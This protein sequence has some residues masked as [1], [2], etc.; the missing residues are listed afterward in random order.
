MGLTLFW[1][2]I[3]MSSHW[4]ARLHWWRPL[5]NVSKRLVSTIL[6]LVLAQKNIDSL[7]CRPVHAPTYKTTL[8]G[9]I[10]SLLSRQHHRRF[11]CVGQVIFKSH[12]NALAWTNCGDFCLINGALVYLGSLIGS[13]MW[14]E[15]NL[16]TTGGY[17][18]S[19][20][21]RSNLH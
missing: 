4:A 2:A 11:S 16:S 15:W 9:E 6:W 3:Q 7:P 5:N 18:R 17:R 21:F 19:G 1:H 13:G 10:H 20:N 8:Q 14:S 12:V